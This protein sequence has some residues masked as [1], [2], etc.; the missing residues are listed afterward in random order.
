MSL[1]EYNEL[2]DQVSPKYYRQFR[3]LYNEFLGYVERQEHDK[4]AEFSTRIHQKL[5]HALQLQKK[6]QKR[7]N[8]MQKQ[9]QVV[10]KQAMQYDFL[11]PK[12]TIPYQPV[13]PLKFPI[14]ESV[15]DVVE[16]IES[17]LEKDRKIDHLLSEMERF[18]RS[19]DVDK[20]MT[21]ITEKTS[22][23]SESL[24]DAPVGGPST[25]LGDYMPTVPDNKDEQG[26]ALDED[27][28]DQRLKITKQKD[29]DLERSKKA[30]M[31]KKAAD[32]TS[33]KEHPPS[34]VDKGRKERIWDYI[35]DDQS[36]GNINDSR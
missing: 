20:L 3:L 19:K 7:L 13:F 4:I 10:Q 22:D 30:E 35:E 6:L 28:T 27:L 36:K 11:N 24:A 33:A 32:K 21:G 8:D 26:V 29:L 25:Q 14:K 16:P 17:N 12:S 5:G 18:D 23:V 1:D 34:G 9:Q 15:P 2:L 31:D